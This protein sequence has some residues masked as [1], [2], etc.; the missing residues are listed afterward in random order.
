MKKINEDLA[1]GVD[2]GKTKVSVGVVD[3]VS[4]TILETYSNLLMVTDK[5]HIL[6][7]TYRLIGEALAHYNVVDVGIGSFGVIDNA[8]GVV[9]S[10]GMVRDWQNVPLVQDVKNRF[11]FDRA[12]LENDAVAA[13][14]GEYVYA[15]EQRDTVVITVG[16]SIGVGIVSNGRIFRGA[17]NMSGQIAHLDISDKY[18]VSEMCGGHGMSCRMLKEYGTEVT[19]KEI[20]EMAR[21]N[22]ESAAFGVVIDAVRGLG[23]VARYVGKIFDPDVILFGGSIPIK[24]DWFFELLN[25]EWKRGKVRSEKV[26]IGRAKLGVD[27]GVF[28]SAALCKILIA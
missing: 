27:S 1:L 10:S 11:G 2:I 21:R 26:E 25:N 16:T 24:N 6:E 22:H 18:T 28:G 8:N 15:G 7:L 20:I 5:S 12:V 3:L 4:H 19:A 13:A 9:L 14:V 17:H 23:H